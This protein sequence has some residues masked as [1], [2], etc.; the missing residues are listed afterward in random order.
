VDEAPKTTQAA[1]GGPSASRSRPEF[2]DD[3]EAFFTAA[4]HKDG[5]TSE[6]SFDDLD[7]G[8]QP[9]GFWDRLLGRKKPAK[10]KSKP[11]PKRR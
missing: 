4:H 6:D 1:S 9:L 3:E 5:H 8:Y 2:S 10:P 11:A 7:D